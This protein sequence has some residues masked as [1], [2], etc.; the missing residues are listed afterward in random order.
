MSSGNQY[1][2]VIR[3]PIN[4]EDKNTQSNYWTTKTA[5]LVSSEATKGM[6]Q[7]GGMMASILGRWTARTTTSGQDKSKLG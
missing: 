7:P 5:Y 1:K 3:N 2:L 6:Y 4:S